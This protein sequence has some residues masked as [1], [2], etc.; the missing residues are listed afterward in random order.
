MFEWGSATKLLVW[1]SVMQLWEQGLLELEQDVRKYLPE[2][3]LQNLS[4]DDPI[5]MLHLMTPSPRFI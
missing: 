2:D 4:Y 1:V 3:F 5:T